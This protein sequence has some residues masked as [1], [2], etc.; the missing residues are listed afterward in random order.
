[1]IA[2]QDSFNT[3]TIVIILDTLQSN[4]ERIIVSM[5]KTRGKTIKEI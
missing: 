2:E 5:L 3:I 1:M 4:F